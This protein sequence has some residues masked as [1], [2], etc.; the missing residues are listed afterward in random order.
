MGK[1]AKKN[2]EARDLNKECL[3]CKFAKHEIEPA[4]IF[5]NEYVLAFVELNP[6]GLLIGHTQVIPK[7]HFETIDTVEDEYL[8]EIILVVKN[9]V[10]AIRKVSGADGINVSQKNGKA[11]GQFINH[12]HFHIIPRKNGDNIIID[13]KRRKAAPMEQIETA[14]LI[15]EALQ[16]H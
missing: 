4:I 5:E 8:K 11:A 12:V 16:K 7:K 3:F 1:E 13:E 10:G 2:C 15:K 6:A 9:L 14:R